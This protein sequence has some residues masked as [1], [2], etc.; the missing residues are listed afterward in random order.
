MH[1]VPIE[2]ILVAETRQRRHFDD[3]ALETLANSIIS[4]GLL[5]PITIRNDT[6]QL[7]AG[8]RR[9]RAVARIYAK[10][11]AFTCNGTSVPSGTVPCLKLCDLDSFSLE[12][13]ELEENVIRVDLTW[14]DRANAEA[15]LHALR[16][17][18]ASERG[19]TQSLIATAREILGSEPTNSN[20]AVDLR[21]SIILNDFLSDPEVAKAGSR[22][23]ALNIAKKKLAAEFRSALAQQFDISSGNENVALLG[24]CR[25]LLAN[26]SPGLPLFDVIIT[27]PPY[28][29]N[30]HKMSAMSGSEAGNTHTYDDTIENAK[31]VW[32]SILSNGFRI[33][34][35]D[36]ALYMFCDFR[37][38]QLLHNLAR[39]CNWTPW[40][41]PIIW[42][43]PGGGMLGDS[44]HGPRKSYEVILFAYKG[45]MRT[46]GTYLDV[47]VMSG[48]DSSLHAAAKPPALY[49]ELLKRS[50][51]P[52]MRVLD[53][54]MGSGPI[55]PAANTLNL[56]AT[57]IEVVQEHFETAL[58]RI[59]DKE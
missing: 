28:G 54:C 1:Y 21:E 43:K 11:L 49:A 18:Q 56:R 52:G 36:A 10:G 59:N 38:F 9:L 4:R 7:V 30:A 37:Y 55:F 39:E 14:Q 42:H 45:D 53:P 8:E 50:C 57:G 3:T 12:E 31:D 44:Q 24:N 22:K 48:G 47:I 19:E 46:T 34:A 2:T 6:P 35:P 23:E 40:P 17:K 58:S 51:V 33:T 20:P 27:D 13:A 25:Q 32:H 5:H 41:T 29:I 16:S 15:R 26:W